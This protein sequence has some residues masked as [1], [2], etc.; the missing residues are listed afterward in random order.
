[1]MRLIDHHRPQQF[2][3]RMNDAT[4]RASAIVFTLLVLFGVGMVI[5]LAV[6]QLA[7]GNLS[8]RDGRDG[9]LTLRRLLVHDVAHAGQYL[10]PTE[11]KDRNQPHRDFSRLPVTYW[12]PQ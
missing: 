9:N 4:K 8:V 2:L 7:E 11:A 1:M 3:P 12:H 6:N 5:M 10:P